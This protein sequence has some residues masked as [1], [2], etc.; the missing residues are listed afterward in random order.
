MRIALGAV[1]C[2]TDTVRESCGARGNL[3]RRRSVNILRGV[4]SWLWADHDAMRLATDRRRTEDPVD[5]Q[6]LGAIVG[7]SPSM[8][9][10]REGVMASTSGHWSLG[11]RAHRNHTK[12]CQER[13]QT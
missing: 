4:L 7:N 13:R 8:R 2:I 1:N 6:A 5:A 12:Y 3:A 10:M 9:R 11:I